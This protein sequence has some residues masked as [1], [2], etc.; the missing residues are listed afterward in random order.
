MPA[1]RRRLTETQAR[2]R[3]R[4]LFT[5]SRRL[6]APP[7]NRVLNP[8]LKRLPM[9]RLL[10]GLLGLFLMIALVRP[11]VAVTD[12]PPSVRDTMTECS[13]YLAAPCSDRATVGRF[14]VSQ[15]ADYQFLPPKTPP[16]DQSPNSNDSTD[17]SDWVTSD[18]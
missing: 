7:G 3:A 17:F 1:C 5:P 6:A 12:N 2:C 4:L 16:P 14:H 9:F 8:S 18:Q 10:R 15:K 13:S 11:C